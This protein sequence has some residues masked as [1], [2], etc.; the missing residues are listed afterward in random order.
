[1]VYIS[2][3]K[4]KIPEII[5]NKKQFISYIYEN[6]NLEFEK[7]YYL[8]NKLSYN[9]YHNLK[10]LEN[11]INFNNLEIIIK[12]SGGNAIKEAIGKAFEPITKPIVG[13]GKIFLLL[14]KIL[15][16]FIQVIIWLVR[17]I[18]WIITGFIP[19]IIHD[20]QNSTM[21]I[22]KGFFNATIGLFAKIFNRITG[23]DTE[24][25]IE[26]DLN[27]PKKRCFITDE[28]TLPTTVLVST[29]LCPPLGVFM[30]YGL[31]GWIHIL[32]SAGLSLLYYIPGLVYSLVLFYS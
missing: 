20:F 17:F 2:N 4:I 32:V 5:K 21:Q 25:N 12:L 19:S 29:I 31:S 16:W 6:Y 27:D 26:E 7:H 30:V 18:V 15:L 28:E 24:K 10:S 11:N 14:F 1:M 3:T 8:K 13:I 22:L 9:Y 23:R